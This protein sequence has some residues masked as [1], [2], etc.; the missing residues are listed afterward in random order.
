MVTKLGNKY[1]FL[2]VHEKVA[3]KGRSTAYDEIDRYINIVTD[4]SIISSTS[5]KMIDGMRQI[6]G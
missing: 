1:Y 2:D 5:G 6:V 3:R 4:E